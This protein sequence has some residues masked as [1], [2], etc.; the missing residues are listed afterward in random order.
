MCAF[1][2]KFSSLH[3]SRINSEVSKQLLTD[4]RVV[5]VVPV[6]SDELMNMRIFVFFI[7]LFSDLFFIILIYNSLLLCQYAKSSRIIYFN[8]WIRFFGKFLDLRGK[9][10]KMK[11][12]I[13]LH[14]WT[15]WESIEYI[16]DHIRFI[17]RSRVE[18]FFQYI[19]EVFPCNFCSLLN[20]QLFQYKRFA[21]P[22]RLIDLKDHFQETVNKL[23]HPFGRLLM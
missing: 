11:D 12:K 21:K 20:A 8:F 17:K 23:V 13:I 18:Y 10:D 16:K 3:T 5:L 7:I 19:F 2:F 14:F 1:L 15:P 6:G 4:S 9:I 22:A